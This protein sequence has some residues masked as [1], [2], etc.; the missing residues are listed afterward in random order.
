MGP[1][2]HCRSAIGVGWP[3]CHGAAVTMGLYS[4]HGAAI[5][6]G[7]LA[8]H[9][10]A[11][12]MELPSARSSH[13]V[14]ELPSVWVCRHPVG[15]LSPPRTTIPPHCCSAAPHGPT[16]STWLCF[17]M[18]LRPLAFKVPRYL[19]SALMMAAA[20]FA[21]HHRGIVAMEAS[22]WETRAGCAK[23]DQMPHLV[24]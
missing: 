17:A 10:A 4:C 1:P 23:A 3:S 20:H 9:G 15:L 13:R 16:G 8:H 24:C 11:N 19:S 18:C 14:V 2:S 22:E 21:P 7:R 5:G 6:V 12:D